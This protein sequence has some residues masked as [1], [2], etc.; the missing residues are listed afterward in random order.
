LNF[1]QQEDHSFRERT[2]MKSA[3][4]KAKAKFL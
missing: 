1:C 3:E 2:Q 4:R